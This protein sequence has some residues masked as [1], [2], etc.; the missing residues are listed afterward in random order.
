[1]NFHLYEFD[2]QYDG[3]VCGIDEAGRGCLAGDVYAAAVVLGNTPLPEL[4]DSKKLSEIKRERL[5]DVITSGCVG[6]AIGTAT[7]DEIEVLNILGA[8]MLAMKRAYTKLNESLSCDVVLIDG[9]KSP[10]LPCDNVHTIVGGDAKSA[11]IA[12]A[13]VLAKVA[14][15]RYMTECSSLYPE[16]RFDKHKSYGTKLHKEMILQYGATPLHRKSFL[17]NFLSH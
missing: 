9:N 10:A 13:S 16:Y 4:N 15:D 12:A 8:A 17:K 3:V 11:A 6:Y 14:R 1:M 2:R 5:F 7:V